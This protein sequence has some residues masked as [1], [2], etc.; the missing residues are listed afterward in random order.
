MHNHIALCDQVRMR[1]KTEQALAVHPVV[2]AGSAVC[3]ASAT[4][5]QF[6]VNT[7]LSKSSGNL[8]SDLG[9]SSE[10]TGTL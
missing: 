2:G 8:F 6:D 4:L 1:N 3:S 5:H 10:L 9:Q 7:L